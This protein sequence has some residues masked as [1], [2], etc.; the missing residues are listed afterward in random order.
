MLTTEQAKYLLDLPKKVV[1]GN[2]VLNTLTITQMFPFEVRYELVSD[3]DDEFIFLWVVKQSAKHTIRVSLHV[4]E[5]GSKIGLLRIDF[6]GG[7][8][9]ILR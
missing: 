3:R 7:G 8:H 1:E 6:N 9:K 2:E 5:N 4:Q